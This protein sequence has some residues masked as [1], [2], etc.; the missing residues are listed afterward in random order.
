LVLIMIIISVLATL[1]KH[2]TPAR[3]ERDIRVTYPLVSNTWPWREATTAGFE[4][5][6]SQHALFTNTSERTHRR[7]N[8]LVATLSSCEVRMC[9]HTVGWDGSPDSTGRVSLDAMVFDGPTWDSGAVGFL[10]YSPH[11]AAIARD[12]M[13]YTAESIL[14]GSGADRF[15]RLM[16]YAP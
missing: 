6:R 7:L 2:A 1:N 3:D 10:Q 8:G 11:A 12:V 5:L 15:A 9:D 16:G 13:I 14:T 4:V